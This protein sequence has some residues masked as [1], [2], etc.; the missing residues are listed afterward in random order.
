MKHADFKLFI[1]LVVTAI[2]CANLFLFCYF[3]KMA[4]ESFELM[5]DCFYDG[6]WQD[7]PIASQQFFILMIGNAQRPLYYHG[8][9]V[10][11]LNLETYNDVNKLTP[12]LRF[13]SKYK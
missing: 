6:N 12:M 3:G 10:A 5:A 2:G 11:V 13:H 4:T 7:L 1:L 9:G 8:F